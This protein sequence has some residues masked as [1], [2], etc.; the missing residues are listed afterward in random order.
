MRED[1]L[2]VLRDRPAAVDIFSDLLGVWLAAAVEDFLH[3]VSAQARNTD[4]VIMVDH[5]V[6]HGLP[7]NAQENL[8]LLRVRVVRGIDLA[9]K[10][11][12]GASDPY[13]KVHLYKDN[14]QICTVQTKTI[15]KSLH[16][17]WNEEYIFRVD[18]SCKVI[19]EVFDENRITRDDFLGTV[20]IELKSV[21][22]PRER[23]GRAI[24]EKNCALR[25]RRWIKKFYNELTKG[26]DWEFVRAGCQTSMVAESPSAEQ[27]PSLPSGWEERVDANGRTFYV[28]HV[29]RSTQWER[30]T[31]L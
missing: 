22:I 29:T 3:L 1:D 30:P 31:L 25:P 5:P 24:R 6:V 11:I 14:R 23:P 17:V 27:Q 12:F 26:G 19:F 21:R 7:E 8:R 16:P 2:V 4:A 9:K 18:P 15:K 10:D 28:N 13:V 20:E